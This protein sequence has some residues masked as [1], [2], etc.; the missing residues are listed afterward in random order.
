MP[1]SALFQDYLTFQT[2]VACS[3]RNL[4]V[5]YIE[6]RSIIL[7]KFGIRYSP[8]IVNESANISQP[9]YGDYHPQL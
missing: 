8:L 3:P 4:R 5:E 2:V 9:Q 6:I 1:Q 7:L